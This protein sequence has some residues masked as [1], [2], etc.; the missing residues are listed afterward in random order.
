MDRWFPRDGPDFGSRDT[1][2]ALAIPTW[3]PLREALIISSPEKP[4]PEP[5]GERSSADDGEP[6]TST[7]AWD[8]ADWRER[9]S[10]SLGM[11]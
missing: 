1:G 9:V 4:E 10:D 2:P 6:D 3:L 8:V 11:G 5:G 7:H